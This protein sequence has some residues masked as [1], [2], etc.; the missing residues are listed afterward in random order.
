MQL[1]TNSLIEVLLMLENLITNHSN[2][3]TER[4]QKKGA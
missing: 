2:H 4:Q 3:V 1:K